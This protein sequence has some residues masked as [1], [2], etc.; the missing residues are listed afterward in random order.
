MKSNTINKKEIEKFSRIAEDT[1]ITLYFF[2]LYSLIM[3]ATFL[4]F[5]VVPTDVPPN[6]KTTIFMIKYFF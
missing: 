3:L 4:I 2:C 1:T 6:F 5:S